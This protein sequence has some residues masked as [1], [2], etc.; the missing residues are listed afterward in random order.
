[1]R[2]QNLPALLSIGLTMHTLLLPTALACSRAIYL[3]GD[4]IV[5]T[6]RSND[7]WG[8]QGSHLWI[9]PRGLDR[10]GAAGPGSITWK[11]KY[12]SVTTGG[13]DLTTIDG[14]NEKGLS[15]NVLYLAESKYGTSANRGTSKPLSLAGWGQYV[16]DNF[17]SVGETVE[18]LKKEEFYI[19]P[20]S[21]PDGHPGTAHLAIS[22]PSGDSAVF[23]YIDGKLV[24]HHSREYQVMT[25]SPIF[26]EQLALN[27]YWKNIGGA[28]MLPGT[29][30]AADRFVRASHYVASV[31]KSDD[32]NEGLAAAMSIIRN[33]SVPVGIV[34]PGQPNVSTTQWRSM[35]DN[36]NLVYY[37]ESAFSPYMIYMNLGKVDLSEGSG[38]RKLNLTANSSFLLD[39]KFIS[40]EVTEHFKPTQAF[41]FLQAEPK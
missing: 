6:A 17:S 33:V 16:L 19:V 25:N 2:K 26:S 37:F 34:T 24:I 11:S 36:K 18:A 35:A 28:T 15:A 20:V 32:I 10:D 30:R 12:G 7:W 41:K 1:M 14:L 29:N 40:G 13:Y 8:S 3:G 4:G 38:A 31:K 5:I 39:G 27:T 23:E 21:T 22:D 9:Y